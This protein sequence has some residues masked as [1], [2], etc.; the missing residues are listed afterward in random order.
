MSFFVARVASINVPYQHDPIA[1][2]VAREHGL[3]LLRMNEELANRTDVFAA[4]VY[5]DPDDK[6]YRVAAQLPKG[7]SAPDLIELVSIRRVAH[8]R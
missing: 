1:T 5:W 8:L 7:E 2:A 6:C 4:S 3:E